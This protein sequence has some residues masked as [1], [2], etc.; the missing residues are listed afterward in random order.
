MN[1]LLGKTLIKNKYQDFDS[2]NDLMAV[3]FDKAKR[4]RTNIENNR[5]FRQLIIYSII[6]YKIFYVI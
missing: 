4:S 1:Y 3:L 2:D 5:Y 6:E